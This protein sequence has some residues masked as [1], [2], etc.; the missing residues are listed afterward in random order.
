MTSPDT[1]PRSQ[2]I[3]ACCSRCA[4]HGARAD[5]DGGEAKLQ[6][7]VEEPVDGLP[8]RAVDDRF[9]V[10]NDWAYYRYQDYPQDILSSAVS[11]DDCP[12]ASDPIHVW[13]GS[14]Q[15]H[16]EHESVEIGGPA[17]ADRLRHRG[18]HPGARRL[19]D[20]LPCVADPQLAVQP[21]RPSPPDHD[22]QPLPRSRGHGPRRTQLTHRKVFE[23]VSRT[24]EVRARAGVELCAGVN[25]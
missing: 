22:L 21:V 19:G 1:L 9:P 14:H 15:Q 17:R 10:H 13:P 4:D 7:T 25:E 5:P 24:D 23:V 8:I 2:T 16:L 6:T 11:L 12:R 20:D 3:H 18:R